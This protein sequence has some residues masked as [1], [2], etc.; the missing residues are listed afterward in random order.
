MNNATGIARESQI[1]VGVEMVR[2]SAEETKNL[3]TTLEVCLEKVL[4]PEKQSPIGDPGVKKDPGEL[5]PLAEDLR[6]I[7]LVNSELIN[8]LNSILNR[9]EL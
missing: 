7:N 8:R 9:L 1:S 4:H 2:S 6:G 5:V 3:I